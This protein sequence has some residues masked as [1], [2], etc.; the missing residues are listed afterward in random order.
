LGS[1]ALSLE[2]RSGIPCKPRHRS[3]NIP[4]DVDLGSMPARSKG[5]DWG[6]RVNGDPDKLDINW[7]FIIC[8]RN[9]VAP[10]LDWF[11]TARGKFMKP[12]TFFPVRLV[13]MTDS[14]R[15]SEFEQPVFY[16]PGKIMNAPR[17]TR[18]PEQPGNLISAKKSF[19]Q[20]R[21][22]AWRRSSGDT[23]FFPLRRENTF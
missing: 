14:I 19:S 6:L 4:Q 21:R 3:R 10:T 13:W 23:R 11:Q 17:A 16:H 12:V 2:G 7:A 5:S 22:I 15:I 20:M 18:A 8:T 9:Q 1:G